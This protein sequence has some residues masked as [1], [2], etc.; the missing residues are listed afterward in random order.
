MISTRKLTAQEMVDKEIK[1]YTY[2][3]AKLFFGILVALAIIFTGLS[4]TD[5]ATLVEKQYGN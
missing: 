2:I 5:H 4:L 1:S 3:N